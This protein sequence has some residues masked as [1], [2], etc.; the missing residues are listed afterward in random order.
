[1]TAISGFHGF[2]CKDCDLKIAESMFACPSCGS[3]RIETI[4][5]KEQGKVYTFTVVH[6]GFGHMAGK[7]PYVLAIVETE[8]NVKLTTVLED[9]DVNQIAIGNKVKFKRN[10]D[11]IG[12]VFQPA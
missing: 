1:M 10:D 2:H 4:F 9:A 8:E 7:T 3:D 6:V 11:K 12:P 5:L